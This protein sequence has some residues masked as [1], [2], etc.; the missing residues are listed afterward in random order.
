MIVLQFA[1]D[2]YL[3]AERHHYFVGWKCS[4]LPL[5]FFLV[6]LESQKNRTV[7]S[8]VAVVKLRAVYRIERR[9]VRTVSKGGK[10]LVHLTACLAEAYRTRSAATSAPF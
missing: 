2:E 6:L 9:R 8:Y 4:G 10:P 7:F 5:L 1:Q 3:V